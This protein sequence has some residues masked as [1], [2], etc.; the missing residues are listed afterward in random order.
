VIEVLTPS[1]AGVRASA[2]SLSARAVLVA[3]AILAVSLGAT[4]HVF[5]LWCCG[6]IS[7]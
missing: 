6:T 1:A 2:W 4:E 5:N 7:W 3:L